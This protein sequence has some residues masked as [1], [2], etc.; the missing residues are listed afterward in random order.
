MH[1]ESKCINDR[2]Q[3]KNWRTNNWDVIIPIWNSEISVKLDCPFSKEGESMFL[4]LLIFFLQLV[5]YI[6]TNINISRYLP[7]RK[8]KS[9]DCHYSFFLFWFSRSDF[10]SKH[11]C[12]TI[13]IFFLL[14]LRYNWLRGMAQSKYTTKLSFSP[15]LSFLSACMGKT[16][17]SLYTPLLFLQLLGNLVFDFHHFGQESIY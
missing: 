10:N 15:F 1:A 7:K 16:I 9:L 4:L 13:S 17:K 5:I 11:W 14:V 8:L 12:K 6:Y 3:R 2:E